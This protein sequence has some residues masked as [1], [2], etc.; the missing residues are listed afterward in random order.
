MLDISTRGRNMAVLF[1]DGAG[2]VCLEAVETEQPIGVIASVLHAQGEFAEILMMEAPS[3]K[4]FPRI[5][6]EMIREGRHFPVMDGRTVFK[7]AVR[8]L[9]E[10]AHEVLE[11]AGMTI[12]DIDMTILHQANLRIN[13]SFQKTMGIPDHK[14]YNNIHHYGN[15][16]AASIPIALDEVLE[17]QLVNRKSSSLLFVGLGAG[18][19][20]G[21]VVF[22]FG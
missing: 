21:G 16:T 13:L 7:N 12:D 3:G 10:V 5:T 9:P 15:T 2:V 11:K 4:C 20:W 17:K 22:R 1:G 19:T 18:I 8:K 14:I 6:E